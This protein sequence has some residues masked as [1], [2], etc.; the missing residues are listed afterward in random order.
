MKAIALILATTLIGSTAAFA[1]TTSSA[2]LVSSDRGSRLVA[3]D[4]ARI[5]QN[6]VDSYEVESGTRE[7]Q[8]QLMI[9]GATAPGKSLGY[10]ATPTSKFV[11]TKANLKAG[12]HY[13]AHVDKAELEPKVVIRE[14]Q[15][16]TEASLASN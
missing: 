11:T 4:G 13:T 1:D 10:S 7:L 2:T 12:T 8:F 9:P 3:V 5:K 16:G 14:K 6:T 15:S